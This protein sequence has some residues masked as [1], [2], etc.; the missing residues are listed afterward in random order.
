MGRNRRFTNPIR[1][2]EAL[3]KRQPAR[4]AVCGAPVRG[5]GWFCGPR[6]DDFERWLRRHDVCS[7]AREGTRN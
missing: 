5:L 4:C 1:N 2:A 7:T 3:P 6:C